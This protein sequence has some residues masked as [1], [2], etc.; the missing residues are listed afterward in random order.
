MH[1]ITQDLTQSTDLSV[2]NSS[3]TF[4]RLVI[5][6][7]PDGTPAVLSLGRQRQKDS[8]SE[9]H[10]GWQQDPV[11]GGREGGREELHLKSR[12]DRLVIIAAMTQLGGLRTTS[13][14]RAHHLTSL[15]Q[16]LVCCVSPVCHLSPPSLLVNVLPPNPDLSNTLQPSSPSQL[17][18]MLD[19]QAPGPFGYL[20]S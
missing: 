10:L 1:S 18:G 11:E 5:H 4:K 15:S 19:V 14:F 16:P 17:K 9:D 13:C 12:T 8:K 6:S 7:G 3:I 20:Q 2:C